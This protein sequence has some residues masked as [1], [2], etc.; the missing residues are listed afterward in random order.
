MDWNQSLCL[1]CFLIKTGFQ[2]GSCAFNHHFK[3]HGGKGRSEVGW[4]NGA[5]V[6]KGREV[7]IATP[8]NQALTDVLEALVANPAEIAGWRGNHERLVQVSTP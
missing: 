2:R 5:V 4:L 8:V 3:R 6:R 1:R 7:N